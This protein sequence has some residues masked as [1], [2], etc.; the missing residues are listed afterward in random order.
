M[1][2]NEA[3]SRVDTCG[4]LLQFAWTTSVETIGPGDL[5]GV[6]FTG[7]AWEVRDEY[8][9]TPQRANRVEMGSEVGWVK[10]NSSLSEA[11]PA[12]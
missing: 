7:S 9:K 8:T 10:S 5:L 3:S 4:K 1:S 6:T 11:A 2:V 12:G